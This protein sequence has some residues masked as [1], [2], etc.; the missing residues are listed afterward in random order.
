MEHIA[1]QAASRC[2]YAKQV[3]LLLR[4][5]L[6]QRRA[7]MQED[8]TVLVV[9]VTQVWSGSVGCGLMAAVEYGTSHVLLVDKCTVPSYLHFA[10]LPSPGCFTS[11]VA[12]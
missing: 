9:T 5:T 4:H 2:N 6:A 3:L 11:C 10:H 8:C 1:P 12:S 7:M